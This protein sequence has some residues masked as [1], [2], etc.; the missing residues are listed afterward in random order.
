[1]SEQPMKYRM[2]DLGFRRTPTDAMI[3]V[4]MEFETWDVPAQIVADFRDENRW[5]MRGDM[6]DTIGQCKREG[7]EAK[8]LDWA[9]GNM[10][11]DDV[12]KH[13]V[14][15]PR[16]LPQDRQDGWVN[17]KHTIIGNL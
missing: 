3:R 16:E 15:V 11:W 12:E 17:G 6:S 13:A 1:M 5:V 10:N 9:H 2:R 8:L 14:R 4:T 7:S